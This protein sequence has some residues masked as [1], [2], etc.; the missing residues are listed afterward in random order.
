MTKHLMADPT[1]NSK[2]SY[3]LDPQWQRAGRGEGGGRGGSRENNTHCFPSGQSLKLIALIIDQWS[4]VRHAHS[5][6]QK[7]AILLNINP[8]VTLNFR[9]EIAKAID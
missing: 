6:R 3:P 9:R 8:K 7:L 2:F 1:G 5:S 4:N